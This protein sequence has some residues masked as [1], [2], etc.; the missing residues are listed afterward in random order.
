LLI[1]EILEIE[2]LS[3]CI[4]KLIKIIDTNYNKINKK[5]NNEIKGCRK[6]NHEKLT[7]LPAWARII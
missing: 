5:I 7:T 1:I 6:K 3:L 4:S 2:F